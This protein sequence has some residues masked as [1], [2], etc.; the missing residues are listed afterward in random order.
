M[1]QQH[2][3]ARAY[4]NGRP[5]SDT[6]FEHPHLRYKIEDCQEIIFVFVQGK[7]TTP[8]AS[9]FRQCPACLIPGETF[10]Y[11][12]SSQFSFCGFCCLL[13]GTVS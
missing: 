6:L 2:Q 4:N 3:V 8:P 13:K 1:Q 11:T 10:F 5:S 9:S 7:V 12:N